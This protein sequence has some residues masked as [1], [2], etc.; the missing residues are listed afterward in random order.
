MSSNDV[1]TSPHGSTAKGVNT[2]PHGGGTTK[3]VGAFHDGSTKL[4]DSTPVLEKGQ[5]IHFM[6]LVDAYT[7]S[8]D[9]G[10]KSFCEYVKA[11]PAT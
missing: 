6:T 2:S 11:S 3:G 5:Y 1:S 8:G 7:N 4:T 9:S 10:A